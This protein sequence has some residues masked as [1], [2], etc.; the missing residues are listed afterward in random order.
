MASYVRITNHKGKP[1]ILFSGMFGVYRKVKQECKDAGVPFDILSAWRGQAEQDSLQAQG[2]SKATFGHS[3]HNFGLA[4]DYWPV[5]KDGNF[6]KDT[7][8]TD[9]M[10]NKMGA[11]VEANGLT[12]GGSFISLKDSDHAENTNWRVLSKDGTCPLLNEAPPD[13]DI[14]NL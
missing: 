3:P 8:I 1:F 7:D 14:E 6:L 12:W 13:S 2:L 5:D 10:W 9:Y 4:F 11:I